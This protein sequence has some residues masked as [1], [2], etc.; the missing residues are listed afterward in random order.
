MQSANGRV[1]PVWRRPAVF[2]L[3]LIAL[4]GEL[5]IAVLNVSAMPVYLTNDRGFSPGLVGVVFAAFLVSEAIFKSLAGHW[6]DK[7]GR[8]PFLVAAP[9]ILVFTP[10]L[11][12][13]V[14][15][16]LGMVEAGLFVAL[17]ALDGLAAAMLW[18]SAYAAVGEAVEDGERGQAM[19]LLNVCFMLGLAFGFPIAGGLN[20]LFGSLTPSFYLASGLFAATVVL[21]LVF[22]PP[23]KAAAPGDGEHADMGLKDMWMC[24]KR[25]PTVLLLGFVAFLAVG[26]PTPIIKL[27]AL[28]NFGLSEFTFGIAVCGAGLFMALFSSQLGAMGERMGRAKA[29]RLGMLLCSAGAWPIGL[30]LWLEVFRGPM[31]AAI[32]AV[33]IGFGFLLAIPAWYSSVSHI[34][35]KRT[36]S[37]LGAVMTAQGLGAIVGVLAGGKIYEF[38]PYS[39]FVACAIAVTGAWVMS[40]FAL[41]QVPGSKPGNGNLAANVE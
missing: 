36:G 33:L 14:P 12:L 38:A 6:A 37:Y 5:G 34:D 30:G 13:L 26:F 41:D 3:L 24:V 27:F 11:T 31:V 28:E 16:G 23:R 21:A 9:A 2:R 39:P 10:L 40:L 35:E 32:G 8:R 19:G 15:R 1:V 29:V 25:V 17:R 18:P 22:A 4:F 20:V 7:H